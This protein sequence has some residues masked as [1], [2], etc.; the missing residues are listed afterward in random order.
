MPKPLAARSVALFTAF[1]FILAAAFSALMA[2]QPA[3]AAGTAAPVKLSLKPVGQ[4]G[5]YF[6]LSMQPGQSRQLTAE[7]GNH[8]TA[9]VEAL[10]Y[11]ADAYTII[12]GGFGTRERDSKASGTT[13][14]LSYPREVLQLPAGQSKLQDFSVAVPAGTAPGQYLTSVVLENNVPVQGTGTVAL[15]Q[16][17]RQ[18]I[19]VSITVPGPLQPGF[20]FGAAGHKISAGKSVVDVEITNTGNANIKPAGDFTIRDSTGKT[21]SQGTLQMASF[22]ART[23]TKV[24]TTLDGQLQPGNYTISVKMTDRGTKAAATA[25]NLPF[26]V[27]APDA[28]NSTATQEN[29]LPQIL[30]DSGPGLLL[31]VGAAA[32]LAALL[33]VAL[34]IRR[35]RRQSTGQ[36]KLGTAA[37]DDVDDRQRENVGT[38]ER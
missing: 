30:Q 14:W 9:A 37:A 27:A 1:V 32:L 31:Y 35:S 2:A 16:V 15:D 7:L 3:S 5:A 4:P 28:T 33:S 21:V 26:S 25:E 11:A 29:Q 6:E 10:T 22:Y 19:A 23:D 38:P 17:I 12:N 34:F 8:G 13:T 20:S 24:E 36:L 18:V